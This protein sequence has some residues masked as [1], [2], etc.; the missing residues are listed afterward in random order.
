[1]F[2]KIWEEERIPKGWEVGIVIPLY[3]NEI[4][5]I[6]LITEGSSY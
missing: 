4:S 6:V 1:M 3:K 5:V 2:N